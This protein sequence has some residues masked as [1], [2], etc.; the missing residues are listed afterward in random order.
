MILPNLLYLSLM[1]MRIFVCMFM[2]YFM[3]TIPVSY[4]HLTRAARQKYPCVIS[5]KHFNQI[6]NDDID[7]NIHVSV[8]SQGDVYKRQALL[9]V[10]TTDAL[11]PA[12]RTIPY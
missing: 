8:S 7:L 12:M 2:D 6:A 11:S 4:T 1:I 3:Q 5:E 9:T 10:P